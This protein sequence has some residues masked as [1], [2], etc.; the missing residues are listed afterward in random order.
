MWPI[1]FDCRS[2]DPHSRNGAVPYP[3]GKNA[4]QRGQEESIQAGLAGFPHSVHGCPDFA[5]PKHTN[6]QFL[7]LSLGLYSEGSHVM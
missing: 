2:Y 1:L 4:A 5:K 6:G 7:P 3:E